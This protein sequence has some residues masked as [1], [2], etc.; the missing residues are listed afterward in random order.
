MDIVVDSVFLPNMGQTLL[1]GSNKMVATSD[2]VY[3]KMHS[4]WD[5]MS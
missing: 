5:T 3:T 1:Q 2:C 4:S